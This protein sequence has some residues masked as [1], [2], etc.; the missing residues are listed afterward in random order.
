MFLFQISK[1]AVDSEM[2]HEWDVR[3]DDFDIRR[4]SALSLSHHCLPGMFTFVMGETFLSCFTK[5]ALGLG[6]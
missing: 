2:Q 6:L 1:G 4:L 3:E 5:V